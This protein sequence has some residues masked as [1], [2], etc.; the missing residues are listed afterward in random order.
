MVKFFYVVEYFQIVR[1]GVLDM[2]NEKL[3]NIGWEVDI[4]LSHT[5]PVNVEPR[6]LFLSMI[7]QSTVDKSM[8]NY[9]QYIADNL[10]F[11]KW[12][13]GHFHANRVLCNAEILYEEIKELGSIDFLQRFGSPKYKVNELVFF[14]FNNGSEKIELYGRIKSID[15]NGTFGQSKEVSYNIRS[16]DNI[17]YKHILESDVESMS[18]D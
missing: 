8:E 18:K 14:Y 1:E 5:C 12:Y 9:L 17:L 7:D 3:E 13:F 11:K 2:I 4:V 15:R 10:K 6:H 16:S